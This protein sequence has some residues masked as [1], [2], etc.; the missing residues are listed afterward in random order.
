MYFA[1]IDP[2]TGRLLSLDMTATQV[3]HFR[4]NYASSG[5]A[6]WIAS[7]LNREGKPYG[8]SVTV[9]ENR[10]RLKWKEGTRPPF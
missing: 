10:M 1:Q 7:I 8:T 2:G 9:E 5:D 4:V 6:A 3:R